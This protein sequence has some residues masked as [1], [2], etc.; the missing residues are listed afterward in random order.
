M[1]ETSTIRGSSKDL[2]MA[3]QSAMKRASDTLLCC[4]LPH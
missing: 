2:Q 4:N 1:I 3:D